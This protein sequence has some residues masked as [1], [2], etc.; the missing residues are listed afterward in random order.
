MFQALSQGAV[1]S[2]F[3]RNEP[4]VVD[5][6]V[7]AV[8][9][10]MPKYDP[11]KPMGMLNG[12]VT[13]LMI[14]VGNETIP[15]ADLPPNGVVANFPD[16]GMFLAIDRSAVIREVEAMSFALDKDLEQVPLR[17]KMSESLKALIN[18]LHPEKKI[19]QQQSQEIES[20]R[21][22]LGAMNT[23]FDKMVELLSATLGTSKTT[24]E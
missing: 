21:T 5:G 8:N 7:I 16:K 12:P 18:E 2:I 4:R 11:T 24:E 1:I 10:H 17:Q 20:L 9:T 19:Q 14:Q 22:Q 13:D 6:K 15:F 3:Y 23:K